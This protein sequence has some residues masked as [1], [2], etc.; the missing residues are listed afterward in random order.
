MEE[1]IRLRAKSE[2]KRL[3]IQS[4]TTDHGLGYH[5]LGENEERSRWNEDVGGRRIKRIWGLDVGCKES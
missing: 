2:V 4:G 1:R 5:S 3:V